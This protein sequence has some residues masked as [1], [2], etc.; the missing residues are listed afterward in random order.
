MVMKSGERWHC[1]NAACRCS[2][3]VETTG[4]IEGRN[5]GCACGGV[6]KK[7]F[8]PPAFRRLDF[9]QFPEPELALQRS[10]EE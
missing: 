3:L 2:V 9:L 4:E 6:L 8:S 7:D 10:A 5:P 1:I